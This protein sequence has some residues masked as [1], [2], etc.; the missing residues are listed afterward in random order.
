MESDYFR[1]M[2]LAIMLASSIAKEKVQEQKHLVN[3]KCRKPNF[4]ACAYALRQLTEREGLIP[5]SDEEVEALVRQY[6]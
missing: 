3:E 4:G 2:N 5:P 6:W 1:I